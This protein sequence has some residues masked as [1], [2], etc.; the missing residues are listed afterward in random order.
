[1][2][3]PEAATYSVA[4]KRDAHQAVLDLIDA[5][6]GAGFIRIKTASD[7]VLAEVPLSDPGGTVS[8]IT[9]QLTLSMA[10]SD[11]ALIDGAAAYAE[12]CSDGGVA[13]L[14]LPATTGISAVSGYIVLNTLVF[15]AGADVSITSAVIG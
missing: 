15:A 7:A 2:P 6:A 8:A 5:G 12:V 1:M 10:G 14:S 4:A 11:S 9:G 13:H 3:A